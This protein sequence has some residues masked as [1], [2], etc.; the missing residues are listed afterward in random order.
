[1]MEWQQD[2]VFQKEGRSGFRW[3]LPPAGE[4]LN[5]LIATLSQIAVDF[6]P[7]PLSVGG[8]GSIASCVRNEG[9]RVV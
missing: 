2:V 7:K 5:D 9:K 1:M 4:A 3:P 6:I 8:F